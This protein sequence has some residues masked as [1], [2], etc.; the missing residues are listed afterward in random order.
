MLS[1]GRCWDS[2]FVSGYSLVLGFPARLDI[3]RSESVH[4]TLHI[5]R[6]E[7]EGGREEERAGSTERKNEKEIEREWGRGGSDC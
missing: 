4:I 3:Y 6:R 5:W 1:A 7:K 2:A